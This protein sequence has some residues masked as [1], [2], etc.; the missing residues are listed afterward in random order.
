MKVYVL[1]ADKGT[2]NPQAGTLNLLNLGWT[3]TM[4]RPGPLPGE[5]HGIAA[6]MTGPQTVVVMLEVE[7]ALCNR[8]LTLEMELVSEDG[9]VVELP[10]PAGLQP[11]RITSQVMVPSPPGAPTG[12]PGHGNAMIEFPNG[13]P[14]ATGVYRWQVRVNAQSHE[15][16][17]TSFFVAP[18]PQLPTFGGP[19]TSV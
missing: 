13:L 7:L 16:W 6:Q 1:L 2:Q 12:F 3:M 17:S 8:Q 5:Q 15:D 14:L 9:E 4:P 11:M 10:G 18:L 19:S